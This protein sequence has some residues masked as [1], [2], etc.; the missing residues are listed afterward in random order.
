MSFVK[1]FW[2]VDTAQSNWSNSSVTTA[3]YDVGL[4]VLS[5]SRESNGW[6]KGWVDGWVG[7]DWT[8]GWMGDWGDG[9]MGWWMDGGMDADGWLK[10]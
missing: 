10:R 9:W 8:G 5:G 1:H 2:V 6:M 7:R 3:P 4:V